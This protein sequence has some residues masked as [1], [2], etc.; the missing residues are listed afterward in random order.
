MKIQYLLKL[1][2]TSKIYFIQSNV[3]VKISNTFNIIGGQIM[4]YKY[5]NQLTKYEKE[6]YGMME[7]EVSSFSEN[8]K[9]KY[10]NIDYV[11]NICKNQIANWDA[12]NEMVN[13]YQ[14]EFNVIPNVV[15]D[16]VTK[17]Q[18]TFKFSINDKAKY[19]EGVTYT[20]DLSN[21]NTPIIK[22]EYPRDNLW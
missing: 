8:T 15:F 18:I 9:F 4:S 19:F 17:M 6:F 20:F 11:N 5:F 21:Y 3:V 16:L 10:C 2:N 22:H 14:D 1:L 13:K 12:F 7:H